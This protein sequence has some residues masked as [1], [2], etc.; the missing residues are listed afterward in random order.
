MKTQCFEVTKAPGSAIGV[1][2]WGAVF[3]MAPP[4][5]GAEAVPVATAAANVGAPLSDLAPGSPERYLVKPGDTLRSLANLFLRSPWR[6]PQL[7]ARGDGPTAGPPSIHPG[8]L[9]VL[10]RGADRA[11]LRAEPAPADTGPLPAL[12]LSPRLRVQ[13]LPEP[14]LPALEP[15]LIEPFL[16][17]PL[18]VDEA[19]FNRAP[20]IVA[21]PEGRVLLARGDHAYARGPA[22]SALAGGSGTILRIFR[23]ARPLRDPVTQAVLGHEAHYVG[24]A[25]L[26]QPQGVHTA[27][28]AA[29]AVPVPAVLEIV[30]A[31]EE[32]RAGD[33]LLPEPPSALMNYAPHAPQV[34]L[35]DARVAAMHGDA[36]GLAGQN[37]VVVINKGL[38]DGLASGHM[39]LIV[40]SGAQVSDRTVA[41]LPERMQLP[42]ERNGL[43]M[44]FRPFDRLSYALV[45][46]TLEGVKVG[47]QVVPAR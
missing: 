32:I 22:D 3:A 23:E 31:R 10:D 40:K 36:V 1:V 42:D 8:Q 29:A 5:A 35:D 15:H 46:E 7:W 20:R 47:D 11:S 12:R 39:L 2:L 17:E 41:G 25:R 19:T 30:S 13:L 43:L 45:L 38:I 16:A 37:Q 27:A 9:L 21:A 14:A 33:R 6:W 24:R 34:P 18:I 28:G 26:R 4:P 44:V